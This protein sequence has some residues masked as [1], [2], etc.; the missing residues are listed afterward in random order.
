MR[1]ASHRGCPILAKQGRG[2]SAVAF[3]LVGL[4]IWPLGFLAR[5]N[6]NHRHSIIGARSNLRLHSRPRHF[7]SPSISAN[8][9]PSRRC[10]CPSDTLN[11][12]KTPIPPSLG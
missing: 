2:L 11:P 8:T 9:S 3:D 10:P 6:K 4:V 7:T 1:A 12:P 5:C